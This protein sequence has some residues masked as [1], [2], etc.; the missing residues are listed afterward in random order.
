MGF[1]MFPPAEIINSRKIPEATNKQVDS[2]TEKLRNEIARFRT[3]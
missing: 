3:R 1:I 2:E